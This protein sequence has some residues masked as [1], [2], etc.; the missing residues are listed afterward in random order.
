MKTAERLYFATPDPADSDR[1]TYW[2]RDK[3]NR[4]APWPA[5]ARYGPRLTHAEVPANLKGRERQD[6][7][8]AWSREHVTPWLVAVNEAVNADPDGAAGRF[9]A[10]VTR[11]YC[12]GRELTDPASKTYGIG[13]ECRT[14]MSTAVL[15][16][17]TE[18]V[19]RA[20]A[21]TEKP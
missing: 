20:H 10:L 18:A 9:A 14:G 3:N 4:L 16:A 8:W 5:R 15:A 17:L 6:W 21:A 19:G 7:I 11:C 2:R 1:M 12:C 13:P